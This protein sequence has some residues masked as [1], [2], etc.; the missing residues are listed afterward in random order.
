MLLPVEVNDEGED[1]PI[2]VRNNEKKFT[3]KSVYNHLFDMYLDRS[4]KHLWK[5]KIPLKIKIWFWLVWH[6]VIATKDNMIKR[7]FT[8]DPLC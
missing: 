3:V 1:T 8:G 2:W 4:F 7:K 6:N 5:G